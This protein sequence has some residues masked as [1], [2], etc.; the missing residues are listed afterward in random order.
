MGYPIQLKEAVLKKVLQGNKPHYEVAKELGVGIY[1]IWVEATSVGYCNSVD[2]MLLTIDSA[3]AIIGELEY[4]KVYI[5]P[6]PVTVGFYLKTEENEWVETICLY[7][8]T[9]LVILNSKPSTFPYFDITHVAAGAYFLKIKS[10][11]KQAVV[12]VIKL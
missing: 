9:G 11:R 5:Y 10:N 4:S 12:K 6:N 1:T 3:N 8:Q 2:S 7:D